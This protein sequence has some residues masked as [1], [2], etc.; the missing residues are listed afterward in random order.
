MEGV[1]LDGTPRAGE[2]AGPAADALVRV[3]QNGAGLRITGEG[4]GQTCGSAGS[5]LAV[6]AAQRKGDVPVLFKP[7]PGKVPLFPLEGL[8][9]VGR[10][11]MLEPAI[12]FAQSAAD[13]HLFFD[14]DAL[15][16]LLPSLKHTRYTATV[17]R[18]P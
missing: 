3:M 6:L 16:S 2:H 10:I 11:G 4:A 15:H 7:Y 17:C 13:A 14:I 18:I 8:D 5:I 9:E 12:D 1:L